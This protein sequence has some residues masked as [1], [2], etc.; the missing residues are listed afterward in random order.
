[1]ASL[2]TLK[3][4]EEKY[5]TAIS[6]LGEKLIQLDNCLLQI[7]GK[8]SQIE[9]NYSGEQAREAIAALKEDEAQVQKAIEAVRKQKDKI[10][11]YLDSIS[12]TDATIKGNYGQALAKAKNVFEA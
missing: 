9:Q 5:K 1:M 10:Q 6:Q 11:S 12:T 2:I 3:V 8:R 4:S 7:Q